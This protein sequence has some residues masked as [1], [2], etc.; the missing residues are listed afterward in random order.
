MRPVLYLNSNVT[1]NVL[2]KESCED[3]KAP[4]VLLE[5]S[6]ENDTLQILF[7]QL[8]E[9]RQERQK[10]YKEEEKIIRQIKELTR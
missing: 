9:K 4:N 6:G 2:L 8:E 7:R 10:I 5:E 3:D 1:L